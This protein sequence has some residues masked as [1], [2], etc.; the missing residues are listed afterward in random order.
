MGLGRRGKKT[1][2]QCT[3]GMIYFVL[4]VDKKAGIF[5]F[6]WIGGSGIHCLA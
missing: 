3:M 1:Q 5:E 6:E 2:F 4:G